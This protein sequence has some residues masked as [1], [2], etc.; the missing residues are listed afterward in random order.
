IISFFLQ[1]YSWMPIVAILG[2]LTWRNYRQVEASE[3]VERTLLILEIPKANDKK[4]LAAERLLASLHGILRD[5]N[6]LSY[7]KGRQEHLSFEIASVNGQIRFYVWVPKSLRNFVEGQI[8]SQY[9]T[10]QI[11]AADEDYV[12]HERDHSVVYTS[13]ITLTDSEFLPIK[14]FQSFEVDPL[15]GITGTLAKLEQTGEEIWVQVLVRPI[16]DDWHKASDR[17]ISGVRGGNPFANVT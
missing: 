6:E 15:A 5:R 7:N 8:Y 9:P 17:W 14:T 2:Y 12:A 4:E 10:V 16:A 1:W 11:H 13:E 3:A